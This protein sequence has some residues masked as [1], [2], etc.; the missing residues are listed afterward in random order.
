M[1]G[2]VQPRNVSAR[3]YRPCRADNDVLRR[4]PRSIH[5][6]LPTILNRKPRLLEISQNILHDKTFTPN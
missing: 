2:L 4:L 1:A 3:S 5:Q 6:P